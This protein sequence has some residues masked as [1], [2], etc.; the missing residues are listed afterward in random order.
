[1]KS[2]RTALFIV[3]TIMAAV[4]AVRMLFGPFRLGLLSVTTPLNP[5][6]FFG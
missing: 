2:I 6:G 4:I 3:A 5:E 1:L